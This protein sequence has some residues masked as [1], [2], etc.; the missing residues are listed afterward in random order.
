MLEVIK[1]VDHMKRDDREVLRAHSG[2]L[3]AKEVNAEAAHKLIE[4]G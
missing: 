3:A 2:R 1:R 4:Q